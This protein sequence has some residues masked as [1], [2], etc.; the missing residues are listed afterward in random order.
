M[1]EHFKRS[2]NSLDNSGS[3]DHLIEIRKQ[4]VHEKVQSSG[5]QEHLMEFVADIG[6]V[7]VINNASSVDI[8]STWY[9]MDK[10]EGR[11]VWITGGVDRG[12]NYGYLKELVQ[13]KVRAIIVLGDHNLNV[14]RYFSSDG[15]SLMMN[16]STMEEAVEHALIVSSKGDTILFSPGCPSYD[17]YEN[18]EE[19]GT[20]FKRAV[21]GLS[22]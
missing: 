4:F 22:R 15:P 11:I 1:K 2:T 8:D 6:G 7:S 13:A 5:P 9:A 19:R 12:N 18:C 21:R 14:L 3:F 17:L 16:A 20:D 10:I